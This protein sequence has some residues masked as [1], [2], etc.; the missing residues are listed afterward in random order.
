MGC[1]LR[2][3]A[4]PLP[5][6]PG[7]V[8]GPASPA[9]AAADAAVL[10]VSRPAAVRAGRYRQRLYG[11]DLAQEERALALLGDFMPATERQLLETMGEQTL[12]RRL[13]AQEQ[14]AVRSAYAREL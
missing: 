1:A 10:P 7:A 5:V 2:T 8:L 6:A 14:A 9:A 3:R 12:H 13:S 4:V 11:T